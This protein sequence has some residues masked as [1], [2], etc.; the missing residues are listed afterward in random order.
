MCPDRT[1]PVELGMGV[2]DKKRITKGDV[3]AFL[4]N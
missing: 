1:R 2:A 3:Y 4:G